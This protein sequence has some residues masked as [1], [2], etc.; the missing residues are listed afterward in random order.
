MPAIPLTFGNDLLPDVLP[1]AENWLI[2]TTPPILPEIQRKFGSYQ[3]Q[4]QTAPS[5]DEIALETW[6]QNLPEATAVCGIGGGVCMDAAKYVSWY[7]KLPLWLAPSVVSVDACLTDTI[8]VRRNG[9]VTYVGKVTPQNILVDFKLI[10]QA[11]KVINR[12]GAGDI[13]SIH[14][15]LW[16]WGL[17]ARDRNEAFNPQLAAQSTQLLQRL[18]TGAAEI[19]AVTESGIRLLIDLYAGE[20]ALCEANGNS[21]PEEGSEHFWAYNVEYHYPR[22]YI[23]GEL[24]ALGVLL[25]ATL[26]EN[27][28]ESIKKLIEKLGVRWRPEQIGLTPEELIFSLTSAREYAESA[29]LAYSVLN[30]RPVTP[31]S[32]NKILRGLA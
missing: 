6:T 20:V 10:Q 21:R 30:A 25:M 1:V 5:M 16:D 12:A 29:G 13:L 23:H 17:A 7:R 22:P 32:A 31:D 28:P 14:T 4:I 9:R 26:Q 15:A 19:R 24:V 27:E 3:C 2:I 11:P 8:G 18:E